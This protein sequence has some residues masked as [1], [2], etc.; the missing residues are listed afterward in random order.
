MLAIQISNH[1]EVKKITATS[2]E[3][4]G[5][6]LC[7]QKAMKIGVTP[8]HSDKRLA[9]G[10]RLITFGDYYDNHKETINPV[11]RIR[12]RHENQD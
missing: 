10:G 4:A 7:E 3:D 6:W 8:T 2:K 11:C 5:R 12:R 1:P 9:L